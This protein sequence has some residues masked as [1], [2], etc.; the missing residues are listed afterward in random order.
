MSL[1]AYLKPKNE[2]FLFL[3]LCSPATAILF[4]PEAVA[5]SYTGISVEE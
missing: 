1:K 3:S 5:A 2:N 4:I